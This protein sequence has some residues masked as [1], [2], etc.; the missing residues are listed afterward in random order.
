MFSLSAC[1]ECN[2]ASNDDPMAPPGIAIKAL[3]HDLAIESLRI[4][5]PILLKTMRRKKVRQ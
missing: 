1:V 3:I 4:H 5:A 2:I